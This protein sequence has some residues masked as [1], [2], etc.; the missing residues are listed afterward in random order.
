MKDEH[1]KSTVDL[2]ER[3]EH[4]PQGRAPY[5]LK[6]VRP[7]PALKTEHAIYIA[8]QRARQQMESWLP[9]ALVAKDLCVSP[10]R[11]RALLDAERI[12]GR[13]LENGYWEVKF[14]YTITAGRR[15]PLVFDAKRKKLEQ[16][17]ERTT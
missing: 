3:T 4:V 17:K 14:P 7:E 13:R 11:I 1:D 8:Q 15:G 12:A 2:V 16:M 10:R 6:V 5:S 9:V